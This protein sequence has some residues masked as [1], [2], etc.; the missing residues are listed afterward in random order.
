[1]GATSANTKTTRN[2]A[3]NPQPVHRRRRGA[4]RG[5][6]PGVNKRAPAATRAGAER[7]VCHDISVRLPSYRCLRKHF[8]FTRTY[9]GLTWTRKQWTADLWAT[10]R[11]RRGRRGEDMTRTKIRAAGAPRPSMADVARLAGVSSQTV[12][13]VSNGHSNVD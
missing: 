10:G 11:Q 12:S 13:R 7:E 6:S 9:T 2:G 4:G 1:M 8:V 5:G 3:T